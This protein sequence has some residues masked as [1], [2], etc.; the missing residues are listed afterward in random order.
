V[1]VFKYSKDLYNIQG[2]LQWVKNSQQ[3]LQEAQKLNK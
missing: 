3:L 1:K 2:N